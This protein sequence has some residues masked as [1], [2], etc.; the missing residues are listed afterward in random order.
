MILTQY[1]ELGVEFEYDD[2]DYLIT[3]I[4]GLPPDFIEILGDDK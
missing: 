3:K 2:L 1:G 4:D